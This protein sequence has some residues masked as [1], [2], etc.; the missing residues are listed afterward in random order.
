MEI[1]YKSNIPIRKMFNEIEKKYLK[2]YASVHMGEYDFNRI[3]PNVVVTKFRGNIS[4][5]PIR[6]ESVVKYYYAGIE[7]DSLEDVSEGYYKEMG[8]Y[9][10]NMKT[11]DR[12]PLECL[13]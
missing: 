13:Y 1:H 2:T 12:D 4:G 11:V 8:Q 3:L 5:T 7:F 10:T 6:D 9:K